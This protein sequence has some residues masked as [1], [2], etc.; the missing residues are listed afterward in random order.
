MTEPIGGAIA[1][2]RRVTAFVKTLLLIAV[3]GMLSA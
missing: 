3:V 1:M 2:A